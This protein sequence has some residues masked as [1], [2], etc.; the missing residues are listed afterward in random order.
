MDN[1][2]PLN[3]NVDKNNLHLTD[4]KGALPTDDF[5][6]DQREQIWNTAQSKTVS[7]IRVKAIHIPWVRYAAA[8]IPLLIGSIAFYLMTTGEATCATFYCLWEKTNKNDIYLTDS[9]LN[10]WLNDDQLFF[11][12]TESF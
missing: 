4:S 2:N 9:E 1:E 12:L 8:F 11:E 6:V 3:D 5:F 10:Q 7:S